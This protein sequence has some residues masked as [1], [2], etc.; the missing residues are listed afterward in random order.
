M[1]RNGVGTWT[2][3]SLN[4]STMSGSMRPNTRSTC[5][6]ENLDVHLGELG[7][8]V[9]AQV[10]VAEA[11]HDLE[12][13]IGAGD[14][15]DLLEQLRRLRQREE[16]TRVHAAGH[17]V[18]AGSLG[19]GLAQDRGLDLPE[20][21]CVEVLPNRH[22]HAVPQAQVVLQA[23]TTQVE[24]AIAQA[25]VLAD[26]RVVGNRERRRL[27]LVQQ[28][29]F[30]SDDLDFPGVELRVY[31]VRVAPTHRSQDGDD[32]F[33]PQLLGI[34]HQR[35]VVGD[36]HLRHAMAVAHVEEQ[37]AAKV[38]HAMDPAKQHDVGADIREAQ[39]AA[40]VGAGQ[41]AEGL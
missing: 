19:R 6:N 2:P 29:D 36:H 31:G 27:G 25:H 28:A 37:Q 40:G 39:G 1:R 34:G 21:F 38:A 15:Q 11:L 10:L 16:L 35:A 17:Q 22:R 32:E 24:I 3:I 14:H 8:P 26:V 20:A 7:L 5:A 18:V 33:R 4:T 23:R 41:G 9:G 12:V 30:V 13:P